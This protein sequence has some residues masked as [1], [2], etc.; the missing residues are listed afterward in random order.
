MNK[1]PTLLQLVSDSP[2]G[3]LKLIPRFSDTYMHRRE[4]VS[5]HNWDLISMSLVLVPE[6]NKDLKKPLDLKEILYRIIV[7]DLD[8]SGSID[9]PRPF[10]YFD[11]ELKEMLDKVSLEILRSKGV[12][13]NIIHDIKFAKDISKPEGLFVKI[14][15][16]IQ[17][18]LVMVNEVRIGNQIMKKEFP[19][20]IGCLTNFME[21]IDN[22]SLNLE[23]KLRSRL[24]DLMFEVINYMEKFQ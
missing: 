4:S 8:E 5:D 21:M 18:G 10:K 23:E 13:E 14:L 7:H 24:H 15:D 6:I 12:A 17:P 11:P 16:V 3:N 9:V 20:V 1:K 19:N 22:E 2:M